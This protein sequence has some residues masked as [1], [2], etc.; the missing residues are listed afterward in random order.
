M[1]RF[2]FAILCGV[3][4]IPAYSQNT[5]KGSVNDVDGQ[6]IPGAT[7]SIKGTSEF[8]ISDADG[9]FT[10]ASKKELPFSLLIS[11]TGFK[12]QEVAIYEV[13]DEP[14]EVTLQTD[15]VLDEV[16]V[17]GY[18]TQNRSELTGAISSVSAS[19]LKQPISSV[20]R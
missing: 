4:L 5:I 7:I 8:A 11:S 1:K 12:K 20:D 3:A 15:N 18:G 14:A 2:L 6:P 19:V 10:I 17:V 9:V 13:T 16:V